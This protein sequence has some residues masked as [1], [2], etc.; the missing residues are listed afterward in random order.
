MKSRKILIDEKTLQKRIKQLAEQI[1]E[2]FKGQ[3]ITLICILKG[4]LYFFADLTK[5]IDIDSEIEFVRISSYIG[6]NSTGKITLKLDTDEKVTGKNIL[7]VEDIIDTGRTLSYLMSYLKKQKP[8][9]LKLVTLLDKPE[10]REVDDIK[11]DYV[12]FTIPDR[13]VIGY[14]L[15]LDQKYRNLPEIQCI[16]NDKPEEIKQIEKDIRNIKKQAIKKTE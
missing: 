12:G 11:V 13:F 5:R 3:K 1:T 10:G 2:D 8:K 7:V 6:T 4:S 14:G 15:D 16:I 9:K